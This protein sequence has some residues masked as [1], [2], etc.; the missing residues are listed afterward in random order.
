MTY[1]N[2]AGERLYTEAVN[3]GSKAKAARLARG[4]SLPTM[5]D[6]VEDLGGGK[7]DPSTLKRM[8]DGTRPGDNKVWGAI[9]RALNLPLRELYEGLGLPVPDTE[10]GGPV[11]EI[12]AV[13]RSLN[14]DGQQMLLM[15]AKHTPSYLAAVG[16]APTVAAAPA[17]AT[18]APE[19]PKSAEEVER[20][21]YWH[22]LEGI[23]AGLTT[24]GLRDLID[25]LKRTGATNTE[26]KR[27]GMPVVEPPIPR[28]A[29]M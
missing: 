8:E 25:Q 23:A 16:H 14:A 28:S 21:G 18:P 22:E 15:F 1:D 24:T 9:W 6:V 5:C 27:H 12:V 26:A 20:N 11:G 10:P 2:G 13:A 3:L 4:Y 19:E 7:L 17:E 29:A